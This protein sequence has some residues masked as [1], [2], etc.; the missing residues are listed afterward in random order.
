MNTKKVIFGI[1]ACLTL[2]AAI[3]APYATVDDNQEVGI[4]KRKVVRVE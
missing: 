4:D 1:L 2:M 3:A